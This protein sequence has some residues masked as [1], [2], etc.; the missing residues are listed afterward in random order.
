MKTLTSAADLASIRSRIALLSPT[1]TRLWGSMSPH[2][3]LCH[4]TD[5]LRLPLGE[6]TAATVK[7][8]L[9]LPL[10]KWIVLKAPMKWPKDTH[11]MPEIDQNIAGTPPGEF[12][13]D[14]ATLLD[15]L[16][17]VVRST[18]PWPPHPIFGPLCHPEWMR[19]GYL[20]LDHH[21]R[22]FGR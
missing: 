8:P 21:L 18:G 15:K 10:F 1:D 13:T 19:L 11:T 17:R 5:G 2:Q 9:P 6:L 22:Q 14:R 16:E 4:I 3:A 12:A 20:H 7:T